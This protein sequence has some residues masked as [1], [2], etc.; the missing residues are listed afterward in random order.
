MI[1]MSQGMA[2]LNHR[3]EGMAGKSPKREHK[4]GLKQITI[5]F[6]IYENW[7]SDNPIPHVFKLGAKRYKTIYQLPVY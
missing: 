5:S 4:I 3:Q 7:Q 1:F 6:N 2:I